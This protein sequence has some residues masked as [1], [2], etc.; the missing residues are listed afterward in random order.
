MAVAKRGSVQLSC[1]E[2]VVEAVEGGGQPLVEDLLPLLR[3]AHCL[4]SR[5]PQLFAL[6]APQAVVCGDTHGDVETTLRLLKRYPLEKHTVVML[7]DYVD[8]GEHSLENASLLLALKLLYPHRLV[9]LRGNHES[10]LV[11]Q[12]Y[13]FYMELSR[14]QRP[15]AFELFVRFNEVFSTLPYAALLKP[16]RLLLVHGGVPTTMPSL[17]QVGKLPKKDLIPSNETAFQLLW[18][19]PSEK[20]EEFSPSERGEGVYL[21]GRRAVERFLAKNKLQGIIR[22]HEAVEGGCSFSFPAE[23]S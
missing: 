7:G 23:G 18:N 5:E 11:N 9:L 1:A 2:R 4:L 15:R 3:E 21:Y 19:D 14:K 12:A 6:K 8:R 17:K 13:G 22:S 16:Y 10:M 20:V